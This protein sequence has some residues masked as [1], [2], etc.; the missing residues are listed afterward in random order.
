MKKVLFPVIIRIVDVL[1]LVLIVFPS[2]A[3]PVVMKALFLGN[4]Y[5]AVNNLP[6]LVSDLAGASGDSL[7]WEANSPGGF[8]FGWDPIAHA[9]DSVSLAKIRERAWDFVILQ[10]QSQIP[11]IPVLRDS[12]MYPGAEILHDSV[13]SNNACSRILFYLSWGRRFG[14][15]QCFVPNYCSQNYTD[16]YQ[17]QDSVTAAYHGIAFMLNDRIAPAGEAW[18]LVLSTTGMVLHSGDDSH[19]N[20]NGSYLTACVFYSCIFHKRSLGNSFTAGLLAD[21][22]LLLQQA[23]DSVVFT[24]PS[25][26][27][28]WTDEPLASFN[29]S[30][31]ADTLYTSNVS[32]HAVFWKWNFGDGQT[33]S[34][35]EPVH[36]YSAPGNYTVSL[37]ACDSCRCDSSSG[38][39]EI[40]PLSVIKKD[41]NQIRFYGPDQNGLYT[42]SGFGEDGDLYV[43]NLNG[44]LIRH[45][46]VSGKTVKTSMPLQGLFIWELKDKSGQTVKTGKVFSLLNH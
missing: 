17:M 20:L 36:V 37:K 19:P 45:T 16:Y 42:L 29:T 31:D 21:T 34:A 12:C 13:K 15:Q 28:L 46:R 44:E 27:N 6:Q 35:F 1:I 4:S 40:L 8:T 24:N 7:F 11:A 10:E 5:T 3:Q 39:V 2:A 14:G 43:F 26:W 18:R 30:V 9:R 33:S 32:A 23:A 38:S 41:E 25:H 22:A